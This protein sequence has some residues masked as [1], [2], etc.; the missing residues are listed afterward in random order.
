MG[1]FAQLDKFLNQEKSSSSSILPTPVSPAWYD[2][3][4][5]SWY[6]QQDMVG[7]S[8]KDKQSLVSCAM[9]CQYAPTGRARCRR[10]G[11]EIDKG[12][13][14]LGYPFR[15]RQ[16]EDAYTL[17]LH[18]ECY[19]SSVFGI[20]EKDLRN[21]I[22]GYEALNNTERQR[23]WKAMR[24]ESRAAKASREGAEAA[25][26]YSSGSVGVVTKN[27]PAVPVPKDLAVPMLPFQKE[28]L[29]WMCHQEEST[30]RGGIL[31]DEMGMGKT[32]QAISLLLAR[33]L[34]GPCLVVCP[35][36]AVQ[37]WVKEIA[38]FTKKGTLRTLVYHGS[39]KGKVA[40]Q[41]KKCDVVITTYQTLESDYRR[42]SHKHRLKCKYCGKLF[43]P[44]KLAFH[45]RYFCGPNAEK[46]KKQQ[47]TAAKKA[48]QSM[49]I[50]NASTSSS[51]KDS[52]PTI[53]NIYRD[54]MKQAGVDVKAKG[55]WNVMKETRDRLQA[56][57]SSSSS[58]AQAG[59]DGLSRERLTLLDKK[60]LTDLCVKK[61]LDSVGRKPELVDRLMEFAVRGVASKSTPAKKATLAM[62]L[63]ASV[64]PKAKAQPAKPAIAG[65][66]RPLLLRKSTGCSS[67]YQGVTHLKASGKWQASF[68]GKYLGIFASELKAAQAVRDAAEQAESK[69]KGG[70]GGKAKDVKAKGGATP[71]PRNGLARTVAQRTTATA[72]GK[73]PAVGSKR[74]R[75][76]FEENGYE[77]YETF[78]GMQL[79]LSESPL[80]SIEWARVVL[81]EAHRIKGRTNSTALA[82][83]ALQVQK[84]Y[85]WCLTGTPLQNRVGELYSLIRFLRV[86]P[87]AFY[88]CKK[89]G[90]K[91]E[92]A[93][94]M[95]ERYCPNCGHVRFMHYSSFKR[96]VS[97]PII[98]FG[99]MGAGKTAFQKL[100]QDILQR[101]MLRRTKEE[102]KADLKLPP[103]KVTIRKDK[104]SKQESDF[105]SSIYMQ[106]CVKFDTFVHSGTVLH[107][108]AHIFDL[109]TSL[110]RAVDHP[111]LIVYG[112][113]QATHKLPSGK[114]LLPANAGSVCGLCQDDIDETG[115]E[116][117]REAK[118]GHVFHDECIR[119]YIADAPALKSGGVG[120]PVCFARLTVDL[121]DGDD[122]GDE[123]EETPKKKTRKAAVC[124]PVKTARPRSASPAAK[125][126]EAKTSAKLALPAPAEG[127]AS[128]K[129]VAKGGFGPGSIMKKVKASEFQSSTKIEAVVDEISK[130]T[131]S[132]PSAKG[133]VFSQFGSMLEL[134]EFRMK[135]AGISCV[136]FR[137]GMSMQARE[138]AL[139]A[140]NEDPSMKVILI[141][142]KAGGEGLNLQVA[143]HVFLL[144][145]WW[146]P[147][148]EMQA[149]QRAH[150]IGQT[151]AVKAVR[152]ITTDT[153]EEKIIKLQEKKQL[154]FDASIDGS[155]TSLGKLTEQDL[156]FL[157]QH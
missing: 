119:A 153:I 129:S 89:Q 106:S 131:K 48:M 125:A 122:E 88:Y 62:K 142:L 111:Y 126:K 67:K 100:R 107:N 84:G 117:K 12:A 145:P 39:E 38:K 22:F 32:I 120:C 41:F 124:T 118:C 114:S 17:Y 4:A 95:R 50:G 136:V 85:K 6:G 156:R 102:R 30:V 25:A 21:K 146:N 121:E 128:T 56:K 141:S 37:Q 5:K 35:M 132:D 33:P 18:P 64:A 53:T 91:C 103:I 59:E 47:K 52:P 130:M 97:N 7:L 96:D 70:K 55:Y 138:D 104:L 78:E 11:E 54:F 90:C 16:S 29:A 31:A 63:M 74:K 155:A 152:F 144:D 135:R 148:C 58:K 20:K 93:C 86:R 43:M 15:W 76:D 3:E 1:E 71:A 140:F 27:L 123:N 147:A 66:K 34:K 69:G 94:F 149:I 61:G 134:V 19:E 81:D 92:C 23:L 40:T 87:Y 108:Y 46:T 2:P 79:D 73:S 68:Q 60:E 116:T 42:E 157:F 82:A 14:R 83:Y 10:C 143:N 72:Q 45:Q 77:G 65:K 75:D 98:K 101:C 112:G 105:Y 113:G 137:G 139:A 133:I 36:A 44:E 28:G 151:K 109:L 8:R 110:R 57:S 26:E 99:Y 13:L 115:E 154:V 51:S 80:H 127:Q 150:R 49:G 9:F 24:S